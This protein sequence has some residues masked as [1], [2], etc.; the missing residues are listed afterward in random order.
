MRQKAE[1]LREDRQGHPPRHAQTTLSR[2]EDQDRAERLDERVGDY[3]EL[4]SDGCDD[5]VVG[6]ADGVAR[7]LQRFSLRFHLR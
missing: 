3:D 7:D 1:P 2:R 6:F 4:S 5:D